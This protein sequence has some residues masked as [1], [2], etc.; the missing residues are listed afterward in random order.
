MSKKHKRRRELTKWCLWA[1]RA[2]SALRNSWVRWED[3]TS[4]LARRVLVQ[5]GGKQC[6][7][8]HQVVFKSGSLQCRQS[9]VGGTEYR[10]NKR[11]LAFQQVLE[12]GIST[13]HE[14]SARSNAERLLSLGSSDRQL[15]QDEV[16]AVMH[17]RAGYSSRRHHSTMPVDPVAQP[18]GAGHKRNPHGDSHP[19]VP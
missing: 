19:G 3:G 7:I 18:Q 14:S 2:K 15:R 13:R 16:W 17:A 8:Q 10:T 4:T 1:H 12:R 11:L 5:K 9:C 6:T